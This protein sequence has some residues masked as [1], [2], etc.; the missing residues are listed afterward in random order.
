[1]NHTEEVLAIT[2][3]GDQLTGVLALPE[4]PHPTAVLIVVGGPQYRVGSHRQFVLLARHLAAAGYAALRFDVRGMG[5]S[6]GDP[7]GFENLS[8]DIG[9]AIDALLRRVPQA[10]QVALWGLCDGASAALL[11]CHETADPRVRALCLVNPWVRTQASLALTRVKHYYR[12][13]LRQRAFWA[14]LASGKV[15]LNA[16]R[17]LWRNLLLAKTHGGTTGEQRPVTQDSPYQHRMAQA[18]KDF[19]GEMLLLLSGRDY[20][21]KEFSETVAGDIAWAGA[22]HHPRLQ[23]H[24]LAQADHTF[25]VES[26]RQQAETLTVDWLNVTL[27]ERTPRALREEAPS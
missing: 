21:A 22:L 24:H 8:D 1:M 12:H 19:E 20:T 27:Q 4:H 7:G 26:A 13:R 10:R 25:S 11:Y 14:K 9:A 6:S 5:D 15:A 3:A 2:C 18:W 17:G 23:L 16:L